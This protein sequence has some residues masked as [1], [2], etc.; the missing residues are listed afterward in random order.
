MQTIRADKGGDAL[1]KLS[2]ERGDP[3]VDGVV[4]DA[5]VEEAW[6]EQAVKH[7]QT[8]SRLLRCFPDKNKLKLTRIDDEIYASFRQ[9]FPTLNVAVITDEVLKNEKAKPVWREWMMQYEKLLADNY[10][11]LT[12]IRYDSS[13]DY[14][15][16]NSTVVPRVQFIA[17]ELARCRE[18]H[19]DHIQ[20][21]DDFLTNN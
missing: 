11:F 18:G 1:D 3:F 6:V 20:F 12:L 14:S 19:N 9:Q 2:Q 13:K 4:N 16:A 8:F 10:H 15:E 17:I 7:A 21:D 5:S